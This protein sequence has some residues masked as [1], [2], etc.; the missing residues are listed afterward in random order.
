MSK[1]KYRLIA[2]FPGCA[3]NIGTEYISN[4]SGIINVPTF[5]RDSPITLLPD[6]YPNIFEKIEIKELATADEIRATLKK[7]HTDYVN[8]LNTRNI[9]QVIVNIVDDSYYKII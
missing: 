1:Y 3:D 8:T 5:L 6:I 2:R 9:L 7:A 4:N